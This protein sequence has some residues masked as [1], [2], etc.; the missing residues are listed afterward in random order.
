MKSMKAT[1]LAFVRRAAV[2]AVCV[3]CLVANAA[4]Q[5]FTSGSTGSYGPLNVTSNTVLDL[6]PDGIFNCT[7]IDIAN[8]VTLSFR[9]NSLNTP[10]YLLAT[11]NVTVQGIIDVSGKAAVG[12]TP[13]D[14]G[15]GGFD[16]GLPGLAGTPPGA[17]YGPGGGKSGGS[18]P[19]CG[20]SPGEAGAGLYSV[21]ATPYY[22]NNGAVYGS[23]LL[24]P[25][26]GG[27]GGGG[28][29]GA[30]GISGGGGGGAV[31]IASSTQIVISGTVK[32]NGGEGLVV[33]GGF[34]CQQFFRLGPGSG[35]AVRI[36]APVVNG[37]GNLSATGPVGNSGR[38]RVET[39]DRLAAQALYAN[40]QPTPSLGA[41]MTV[42][43]PV[44]PRLD[45]VDVAGTSIPPG[46]SIPVRIQ[47]PYGTNAVQNVTVQAKDFNGDVP[48]DIVLTPDSGDPVR[49]ALVIS[50]RVTNP[51]IG[52][53]SVLF[54]SNTVV[55]VNAWTR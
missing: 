25:L 51:A 13:G 42:F 55:T 1:T 41:H 45:I 31:L 38:I 36:V 30:P 18:N 23:P 4:G 14:G 21:N 43:L 29:S 19:H 5:G 10:V 26:V 2:N 12:V 37:S 47:L 11:S 34:P 32:A 35:G 28:G 15:P 17:G 8:G 48:I 40:S 50:N 24:V 3:G 54:P 46:T 9:R 16:G 22:T 39:L 7:T 52:V 53:A 20:G 6:P 33:F 27:S 49:Y 44:A